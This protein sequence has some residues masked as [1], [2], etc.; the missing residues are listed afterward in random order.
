MGAL[1]RP[2]VHLTSGNPETFRVGGNPLTA[3]RW[4]KNEFSA[5]ADGAYGQN[6]TKSVVGG[7]LISTRS[8]TAQNYGAGPRYNRV[9]ISDRGYL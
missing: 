2:G 8:T 1:R 6:T 7:S 4:D 3:T 5:N 9:V